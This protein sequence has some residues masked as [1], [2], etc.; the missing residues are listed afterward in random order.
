MDSMWDRCQARTELIWVIYRW[1]DLIKI[2]GIGQSR[3][4]GRG[5]TTFYEIG[6]RFVLRYPCL[7]VRPSFGLLLGGPTSYF[8]GNPLRLVDELT[9]KPQQRTW[10]W[11]TLRKQKK[12]IVCFVRSYSCSYYILMLWK[13]NRGWTRDPHRI[14]QLWPIRPVSLIKYAVPR[15]LIS[16]RV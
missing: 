16:G 13:R 15:N 8:E 1:R 14:N 7:N 10:S 11:L 3:R 4:R 5:R 6:I 9:S 12:E 2:W